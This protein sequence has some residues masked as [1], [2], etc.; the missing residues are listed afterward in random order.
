MSVQEEKMAITISLWVPD[1]VHVIIRRGKADPKDYVPVS[2]IDLA[3]Y[4]NAFL[5]RCIRAHFKTA[6]FHNWAGAD[7]QEKFL[8]GEKA[9]TVV[10]LDNKES[11]VITLKEGDAGE[12]YVNR[13][14]KN[15]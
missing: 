1:N 13:E 12:V 6:S 7:E 2:Y 14:T 9:R 5:F 15:V 10:T 11:F 4:L 8:Q 3:R